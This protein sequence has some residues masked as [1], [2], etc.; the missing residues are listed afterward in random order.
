[1]TAKQ[2][3]LLGQYTFANASGTVTDTVDVIINVSNGLYG[4]LGS[5]AFDTSLLDGDVQENNNGQFQF[6]KQGTF[7]GRTV[8]LI[9]DGTTPK[10][11][12]KTY[13]CQIP[14]F[15]PLYLFDQWLNGLTAPTENFIAFKSR[16]GRRTVKGSTI[17][18]T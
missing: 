14:E 11:Y 17:V 6:P 12:V 2:P 8:T 9:T 15:F 3:V 13:Q 1:M 16:G 7:N 10:G 18:S 4:A 5:P